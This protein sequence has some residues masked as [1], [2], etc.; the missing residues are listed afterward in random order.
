MTAMSDVTRNGLPDTEEWRAFRH[1][2]LRHRKDLER[3]LRRLMLHDPRATRARVQNLAPPDLA[4]EA[5]T[6]VLSEWRAKP[7]STSPEQWMRKRALQL[8]DESLDREALD[9]ES[10]AE[11]RFEERRLR[12]H[13]LLADDEDRLRW[14]ELLDGSGRERP[15]PFDGLAADD[16]V[17]RVETRLAETATFEELDRALARLPEVPRRIVVHRFLDD[18]GVDD[19]AYLLDVPADEVERQLAEA[20]RTL[21]HE[22]SAS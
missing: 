6:W 19:I 15:V 18:L 5:F 4:D 1:E 13:E 16:S 20:V 7:A 12:R 17:S 8:L 11:E 22:L 21:R 2:A 3:S 14:R 9:A 10:R